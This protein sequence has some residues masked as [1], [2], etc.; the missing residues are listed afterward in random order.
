MV[1]LLSLGSALA[2]GL[3]DFIGGLLSRRTSPWAIA[4]SGQAAAT[5]LTTLLALAVD[6]DP[7]PTDWWWAALAGVGSGAGAGFL[8]R[9]LAS[10][11][12]GVVAPVSAVGAALL[13]VVVGIALGERPSLLTWIGVGCALPAIWL[14]SRTTDDAGTGG[15]TA[16][17]LDGVLAGLGFGL[18]F[19]A[20]GQVGDDS[21]FG[22]LALTQAV[23]VVA[24]VAL[25]VALRAAWLPRDR[26]AAVGASIGVLSTAATVLFQ[27]ATRTGLLAVAAVLTSLYP[28]LTVLLA[29][30][31]LREPIGRAQGIGLGLAALAVALVAAG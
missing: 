4:V 12:M 18:L 8:Y 23:A 26:A 9:G 27:L 15:A 22:P 20:L 2:Y 1:V 3:S 29:T 24:T 31:V 10:G 17:L 21:G 19:A 11:R 16:G 28:A 7:Q 25:A 6:G 5:V 30:L 14:V 13:P